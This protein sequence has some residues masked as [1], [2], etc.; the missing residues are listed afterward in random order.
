M[1]YILFF[2]SLQIPRSH[3]DFSL[4]SQDPDFLGAF[5]VGNNVLRHLDSFG[6]FS[7]VGLLVGL[8]G[9]HLY[10]LI[11]LAQ[12]RCSRFF[13]QLVGVGVGDP[14]CWPFLLVST[15]HW[16]DLCPYL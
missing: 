12:L 5:H 9:F 10:I 8:D 4:P 1:I 2:P 14:A 6:P 13:V 11:F 15:G 7:F 16:L 3:L